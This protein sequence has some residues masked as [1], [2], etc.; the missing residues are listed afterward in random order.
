MTFALVSAAGRAEGAVAV[1]R[2]AA[3]R[4]EREKAAA[5]A[6]ASI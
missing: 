5:K 1:A 4:V 6:E 3:E 2:D